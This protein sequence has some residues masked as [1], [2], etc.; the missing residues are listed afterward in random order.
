MLC[1]VNLCV[2]LKNI[3]SIVYTYKKFSYNDLLQENNIV[4]KYN[5]LD[6]RNSEYKRL[7]TMSYVDNKYT[8]IYTDI[9]AQ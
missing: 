7:T 8:F 5:I 2:N 1:V 4:N 9:Q 6:K 3:L